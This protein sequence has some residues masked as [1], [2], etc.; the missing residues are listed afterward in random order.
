MIHSRW[1]H[2]PQHFTLKEVLLLVRWLELC[3]LPLQGRERPL[4]RALKP[5]R[6]LYQVGA[7]GARHHARRVTAA[8][9]GL[10]DDHDV[11]GRQKVEHGDPGR[12]HQRDRLARVSRRRGDGRRPPADDAE[13]GLAVLRR[14]ISPRRGRHGTGMHWWNTLH[15]TRKNKRCSGSHQE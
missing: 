8:F 1:N 7:G 2:E 6:L 14:G 9:I 13:V 4:V 10:R 3:V 11:V 15:F 5:I 12:Q